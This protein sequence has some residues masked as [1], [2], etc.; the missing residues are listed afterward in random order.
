ME[1]KIKLLE[2]KK[3]NML[4]KMA[5]IDSSIN[6]IDT[7]AKEE[8]KN[9]NDNLVFTLN[10]YIQATNNKVASLMNQKSLIASSVE[11]LDENIVEHHIEKRKY[12]FLIKK[13][14]SSST[15]N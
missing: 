8:F 10:N 9:I 5:E 1:K 4:T 12:E 6:N 13:R 3:S 14:Y 2:L 7:Q 15:Y 11:E